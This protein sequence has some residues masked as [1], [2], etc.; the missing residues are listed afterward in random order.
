MSLV[1]TASHLALASVL[2]AHTRSI[3]TSDDCFPITESTVKVA[4]P[5]PADCPAPVTSENALPTTNPPDNGIPR[6]GSKTDGSDGVLS[7]GLFGSLFIINRYG[8]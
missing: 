8:G 3:T 1:E 4:G 6:R 7:V 5:L 2:V